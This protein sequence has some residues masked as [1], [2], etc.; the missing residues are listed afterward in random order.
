MRRP[1]EDK[2]IEEKEEKKKNPPTRDLEDFS[3]S[4]ISKF[5]SAKICYKIF[6]LADLQKLPFLYFLTP[7]AEYTYDFFINF[8][9]RYTSFK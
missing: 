3:S 9:I 5:K 7:D 2:V 1:K 8:K 6:P 4:P